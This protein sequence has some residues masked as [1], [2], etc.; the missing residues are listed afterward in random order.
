M[1]TPH[2]PAQNKRLQCTFLVS[3]TFS[4]I[5]PAHSSWNGT[6]EREEEKKREHHNDTATQH[7]NAHVVG[8]ETTRHW[9]DRNVRACVY[10]PMHTNTTCTYI[11]HNKLYAPTLTTPSP[12]L[13]QIHSVLR[14]THSQ[15]VRGSNNRK[16][17]AIIPRRTPCERVLVGFAR[18][19]LF[20]A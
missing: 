6:N 18:P 20:A 2:K 5:N 10:R 1:A 19:F 11:T 13:Y 8:N 3:Y 9:I 7:A 12:L 4:Y 14:G 15:N 16:G 17:F